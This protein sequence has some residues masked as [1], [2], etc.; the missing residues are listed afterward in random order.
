MKLVRKKRTMI[1]METVFYVAALI[2][3]V[4]ILLLRGLK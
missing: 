2:L 3:G 1:H 4:A